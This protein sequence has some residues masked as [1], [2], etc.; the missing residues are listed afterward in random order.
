MYKVSLNVCRR[1]DSN[2]SRPA[3]SS[4][5]EW[6]LRSRDTHKRCPHI[7]T[8]Y[9]PRWNLWAQAQDTSSGA[10]EPVCSLPAER[11][12]TMFLV[13]WSLFSRLSRIKDSVSSSCEEWRGGHHHKPMGNGTTTTQHHGLRLTPS[14][15]PPQFDV[16]SPFLHFLPNFTC[17]NLSSI[18]RR[19][20]E[21]SCG[22]IIAADS[23]GPTPRCL[24]S[25]PGSAS[26]PV[27]PTSSLGSAP[28]RSGGAMLGVASGSV[29]R[30]QLASRLRIEA[31]L[32]V[33]G[34]AAH[35]RHRSFLITRGWFVR[36]FEIQTL[37]GSAG[38]HLHTL[39]LGDGG[40]RPFTNSKPVW[41]T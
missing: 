34:S 24:C 12:L 9:Y 14:P 39:R 16:P 26:V 31:I 22:G 8:V 19:R 4:V 17:F 38:S 25:K 2:R 23:A 33:A 21:A 11:L 1:S 7:I 5:R 27:T 13:S 37:A 6:R 36:F 28:G 15:L 18:S 30:P 40:R 10:R 32:N 35:L 3:E 29:C 41:I 20:A